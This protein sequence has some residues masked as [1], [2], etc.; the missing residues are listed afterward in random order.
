MMNQENTFR[1]EYSAEENKEI[2]EIRKKY[3]PKSESK[4]EELKRLDAQV[5]KSGM[6]EALCIG[7][8]SCLVFGL[9]LCLAMKVLGSTIVTVILGV[10]IGLI[11]MVGMGMAYPLYRKKQEKAK[12]VYAPRILELAEELSVQ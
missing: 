4:L 1:Y 2:Q 9:G 12:E 6:V 5:Q 7:I 8:I 10:I 11:G 3:L